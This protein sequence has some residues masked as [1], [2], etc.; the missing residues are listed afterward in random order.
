MKARMHIAGVM[1]RVKI[2]HVPWWELEIM[3]I[4]QLDLDQVMHSWVSSNSVFLSVDES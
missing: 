3:I 1:V 4:S 2:W